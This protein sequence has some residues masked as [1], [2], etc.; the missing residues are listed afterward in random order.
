MQRALAKAHT[1][2]LYSRHGGSDGRA[3]RTQLG[4][5]RDDVKARVSEQADF[6]RGFVQAAPI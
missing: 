1:A 2:A 6:L 4:A 3:Q 5:E